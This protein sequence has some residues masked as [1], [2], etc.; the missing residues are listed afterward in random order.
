L[1]IRASFLSKRYRGNGYGLLM[2]KIL[3]KQSERMGLSGIS[4][5]IA[6]RENKK[7]IPSI[8]KKLEG[9]EENGIGYIPNENYKGLE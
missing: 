4:S 3:L 6:S 9:F 7:Q 5:E 8:Y 2:Y 1:D